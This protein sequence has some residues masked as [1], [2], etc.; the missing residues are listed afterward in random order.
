MQR[1]RSD[2]AC[3]IPPS[4]CFASESLSLSCQAVPPVF[5]SPIFSASLTSF[6]HFGRLAPLSFPSLWIFKTCA[7]TSEHAFTSSGRVFLS[8]WL[9]RRLP[10]PPWTWSRVLSRCQLSSAPRVICAPTPGDAF[11]PSILVHLFLAA[12]SLHVS[13]SCS[14]ILS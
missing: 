7:C 6:P 14:P 4:M 3:V 2:P 9:T 13:P 5:F 10:H 12:G 11:S 8:R 1:N